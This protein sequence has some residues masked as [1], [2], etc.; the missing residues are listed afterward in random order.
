MSF[1]NEASPIVCF[2]PLC[3]PHRCHLKPRD[4]C[5]F[6]WHFPHTHT[7]AH[8]HT[9]PLKNLWGFLPSHLAHFWC[10]IKKDKMRERGGSRGGRGSNLGFPLQWKALFVEHSSA[11]SPPFSL[12]LN[13]PSISTL[14]SKARVDFSLN[15]IRNVTGPIHGQM[16]AWLC[17]WR[18]IP[19][20]ENDRN[21]GC[22]WRSGRVS[23]RTWQ[24]KKAGKKLAFFVRKSTFFFFLP[25][26][27]TCG[28]LSPQFSPVAP[29]LFAEKGK[30]ASHLLY[31]KGPS[32]FSLPFS[33]A[34]PSKT[35]LSPFEQKEEKKKLLKE[36]RAL[37]LNKTTYCASVPSDK[38]GDQ[39]HPLFIF[40]AKGERWTSHIVR[41]CSIMSWDN[42]KG[43]GSDEN[44]N[45]D[46]RNSNLIL[47]R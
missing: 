47:W 34:P 26:L 31:S 38:Q 7:Y 40:S 2:L 4:T 23:Q 1:L 32:V 25:V 8:T 46:F 43:S 28:A 16:E 35:S 9:H 27:I 41:E 30:T 37:Y 13:P 14:P 6:V 17:G 21:L 12:Q 3:P 5:P 39:I 18:P 22:G 29:P 33:E 45:N 42:G 19:S 11:T 15:A 10:W 44:T 24:K 20:L 36:L